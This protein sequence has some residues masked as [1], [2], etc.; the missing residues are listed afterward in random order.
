LSADPCLVTVNRPREYGL[1]FTKR[2]SGRGR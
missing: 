2:W 1:S